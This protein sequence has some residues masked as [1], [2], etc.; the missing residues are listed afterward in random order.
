MQSEQTP[1]WYDMLPRLGS[2]EEF[3]AVRELFAR[4][5]FEYEA[6]CRRIGVPQLFLLTSELENR[7]LDQPMEG[8]LDA[9]VR[10]FTLGRSLETAA[11]VGLFGREGFTALT[12]LQLLAPR[13]DQPEVSFSPVIIHP[14]PGAVIVCDRNATPDGAKLPRMTADV[15]Y[16]ALFA[17]TLDFVARF[18]KTPC[19]NVLEIGTGTG[20]AAIQWSR[21]AREVWATDITPRAAHF[22]EFNVRL[23]GVKNVRVAQGDLYA[24]VNGMTFDRI[25]CHPPFVPARKSAVIFRDGGDDGEQI[26][27]RIIE[28]LP[29]FLRPNGLFWASFM[30]SDRQHESAEQR[31]RSWLGDANG[32]FDIGLSVD[33][34]RTVAETIAQAAV[35]GIGTPE[36]LRYFSELW[37]ANRTHHLVHASVLIR[38]HGQA[39]EPVSMRTQSGRGFT[40]KDLEWLLDWEVARRAPGFLDA[41]L[42]SRPLLAQACELRA[43]YKM[44]AGAVV[45]EEYTV[46]AEGPLQ[47]SC[48]CPPW[49]ARMLMECDGSETA[50][51]RLA[52]VREAGS[53]P[54]DADPAEFARVLAGLAA[55]GVITIA[56]AGQVENS[57]GTDH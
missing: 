30:I 4:N 14:A 6:V 2:A 8:A 5:G 46:Q 13:P 29:R 32:E 41:L 22:A 12:A 16:P 11:A 44:Q 43:T 40:A 19:E 15:L 18:P 20:T 54:A 57:A 34:R 36:D 31:M 53:I 9:F 51:Q 26:A 45:S 25:A 21:V 37:K 10:V 3:A 49:M 42:E 27:R 52:R 23:A 50:R 56:L 39:R 1:F 55:A 33:S 48:K 38:R 28:G 35:D 7:Y 24:P 17:N 47:V